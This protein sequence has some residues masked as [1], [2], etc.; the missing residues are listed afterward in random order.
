[1]HRL[2]ICPQ[3]HSLHILGPYGALNTSD[4]PLHTLPVYDLWL[5]LHN[6]QCS[7]NFC[8]VFSTAISIYTNFPTLKQPPDC[9]LNHIRTSHIAKICLTTQ[10]ISITQHLK[11]VN[12]NEGRVSQSYAPVGMTWI[13]NTHVIC[14]RSFW[15]LNWKYATRGGKQWRVTNPNYHW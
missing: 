1:M 13:E 9:T 15:H 8:V 12:T 11:G 3:I 10:R 14:Q 7:P 2:Y 5:F 4:T 6:R